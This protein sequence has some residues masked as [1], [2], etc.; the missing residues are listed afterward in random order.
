M[1]GHNF[2][3][4]IA[5]NGKVAFKESASVSSDGKH[6]TRIRQSVDGAGKITYEY[7]RVG[8]APR[9][10][11][12]WGTWRL[13]AKTPANTRTVKV[14]GENFEWSLNA[15]ELAALLPA[16]ADLPS[17]FFSGKLD[18][19]EYQ[20]TADGDVLTHRLR[21][22]DKNTI[23]VISKMPS[24]KMPKDLEAN[25]SPELAALYKGQ[26]HKDLWQIKGN[27]LSITTSIR[28]QDGSQG[29][30]FVIEYERVK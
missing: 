17:V 12:F 27:I 10:D 19:K 30:P 7:D 25:A 1:D 4:T 13:V 6:Y 2:R 11:V 29:S 8:S 24:R 18:G 23:E 22:I 28:F 21:R 3:I 9:G 16:A 26:E 20:E 5:L 15:A 14:D